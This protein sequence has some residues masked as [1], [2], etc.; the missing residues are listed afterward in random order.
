MKHGPKYHEMPKKVKGVRIM[1][2]N[3]EGG[4]SHRKSE[5]LRQTLDMGVGRGVEIR[6]LYSAVYY[7]DPMS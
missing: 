7:C 1:I 3:S 6:I 5:V 4:S 2:I